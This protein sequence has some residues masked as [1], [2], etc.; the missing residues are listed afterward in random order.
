MAIRRFQFCLL[1]ILF[2]PLYLFAQDN[3][4]ENDKAWSLHFEGDLQTPIFK[5]KLRWQSADNVLYYILSVHDAADTPAIEPLTTTATEVELQ[6]KPG[7]YR[8]KL[9]VFNL[10]GQKEV[11]TPWYEFMVKQAIHPVINSL[12][13]KY[14]YIEDDINEFSIS[15]KGFADECTVTIVNQSGQQ[16]PFTEINRSEKN[17]HFKSKDILKY[18]GY[19]WNIMVAHPSGLSSEAVPLTVQ[20]RRPIDFYLGIGY[21]LFIPLTDTWYRSYWTKKLYPIT[22]S[23]TIGLIFAKTRYGNVGAEIRTMF[24]NTR[25]TEDFVSIRNYYILNGLCL[26]YEYW[27]IK[28]LAFFS[29]LGGGYSYSEFQFDFGTHKDKK[30]HSSDAYYEIGTGIRWKFY[31]YA[32]IEAGISWQHILHKSVQ[33]GGIIPEITVGFRY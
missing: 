11:E 12:S 31:R 13:P 16:L 32:Y 23:G 22:A 21:P 30:V 2:I 8:Y 1:L 29:R 3:A 33:I 17:I 7:I 10:L 28:Q 9:E 14:L 26:N 19:I 6:L 18:P 24:R 25:L 15:G 27:F 5:Q 20:Y 4:A